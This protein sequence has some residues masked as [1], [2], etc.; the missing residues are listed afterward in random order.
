MALTRKLE[1][2]ALAIVLACFAGVAA[3][4]LF[5]IEKTPATV[6]VL[7]SFM[8]ALLV[9]PI[10]RMV[11]SRVPQIELFCVTLLLLIGFGWYVW[12]RKN[13]EIPVA[14]SALREQP[15]PTPAPQT[16]Q[17]ETP[18]PTRTAKKPKLKTV[19]D[20]QQPK[21]DT[22]S[23]T[24]NTG[25]CSNVQFGNN[26]QA[27]VNCGSVPFRTLTESQKQGITR[28]LQTVPKSVL[29]AVG[30]VYGSGDAFNYAGDFLPLFEGRLLEDQK[31][32]AIRTGFP[33]TFT[34]VIVATRSEDDSASQYRNVFVDT[35]ISLGIPARR[36]NGSKVAPGNIEFLVGY[37]PQEVKPQ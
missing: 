22:S 18:K 12:P 8:A 29:I 36:G 33:T 32:P 2:D 5:L 15:K 6:I 26:N 27:T 7:L 31:I 13:P 19:P 25:P 17:P 21:G 1:G 4:A 30:G 9:Y 24:V 23:P 35:L 34:D 14:T 10:Y 16:P 3:F 37:R 28:F 11:P 20:I